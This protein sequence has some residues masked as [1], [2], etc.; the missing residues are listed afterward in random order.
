[1]IK[2]LRNLEIKG[3]CHNDFLKAPKKESVKKSTANMIFHK[4]LNVFLLRQGTKK[5]WLFSSLSFNTIPQ[6]LATKKKKKKKHE[7]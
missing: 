6:V 5:G 7:K 2:I 3:N 1:M 4:E